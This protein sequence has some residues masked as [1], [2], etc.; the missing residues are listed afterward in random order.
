MFI[1]DGKSSNREDRKIFFLI[2]LVSL[3]LKIIV[4]CS[5]SIPNEDAIKYI[6][7]AQAFSLGNFREAIRLYPLPLYPFLISCVHVVIPDWFR[8]AQF[9]SWLPLT[10]AAIPLYHLAKKQ[11]GARAALWCMAAYSLA[12]NFNGYATEVLRDPLGLLFISLAIVYALKTFGKASGRNLLLVSVFSLLAFLTRIETVFFPL[13]FLVFC[14]V[15]ILHRHRQKKIPLK[16]I[17]LFIILPLGFFIFLWLAAPQ[18]FRFFIHLE[19]FAKHFSALMNANYLEIYHQL[20]DQLGSLSTSY[21]GNLFETTKHYMWLVYLIAMIEAAAILIFPVNILPLLTR[22]GTKTKYDKNTFFIAGLIFLFAATTYLNLLHKNLLSRRYLIIPVFLLFPWVGRGLDRLYTMIC[23]LNRSEKTKK[24]L[25]ILFAFV[26]LA[27]PL[28]KTL[29]NL[30]DKN[31]SLKQACTWLEHYTES[32]KSLTLL[33]NDIRIPF[34]S[35]T[36]QK[37]FLYR[38]KLKHVERYARRHGADLLIIVLSRKKK[39]HLPAFKR[40]QILKEFHDPDN[41]IIIARQKARPPKPR[42]P[43]NVDQ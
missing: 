33:G 18:D 22:G 41:I 38:V 36:P 10:L 12:P 43:E 28:A 9:L 35:N 26:F 25:L 11:F 17:G 7:A 29:T 20:Y 23:N 16:K 30:G 6:Y 8:A 2:L 42:K 14:L 27:S 3:A 1:N 13:F 37:N 24:A 39:E 15:L 34:L 40:Y 4:S 19:L 21:T 31:L 5:I 32:N